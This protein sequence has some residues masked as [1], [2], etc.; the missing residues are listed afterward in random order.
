MRPFFWVIFPNK[1]HAIP[2]L[3]FILGLL[4]DW[5]SSVGPTSKIQTARDS[6]R[7]TRVRYF[8]WGLLLIELW[9]CHWRILSR[10]PTKNL[11]SHRGVQGPGRHGTMLVFAL[12]HLV[13]PPNI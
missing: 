11:D 7:A 5:N 2:D 3:H 8:E 12:I 10:Q 6:V 9:G 1:K 4:I 13:I